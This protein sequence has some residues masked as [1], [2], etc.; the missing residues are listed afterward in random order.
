MKLAEALSIRADLQRK[1]GQLKQRLK[2]SSKVQ[3][4]DV[5]IE[6]VCDLYK[7]LDYCFDKLEKLIY[8]INMTNIQTF[9]KGEN[10]TAKIAKK[11]ILNMRVSMFREIERHVM[12]I[13]RY[14]RN[15]IKYVRTIDIK[16]FHKQIDTY[17]KELRLLDLEIQSLNWQTDLL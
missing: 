10:I 11:D 15:E 17:S 5:P 4:G 13:E 8:R 2:D 1:I 7:E 9:S 12:E 16:D 14:G 3:E 6:N